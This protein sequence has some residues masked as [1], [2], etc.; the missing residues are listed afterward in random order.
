MPERS[1]LAGEAKEHLVRLLPVP[2]RRR[3][4]R[5]DEVQ[6]EV[7]WRHRGGALVGR[8]KEQVA[9]PRRPPFPPLQLMLPDLI[10]GDVGRVGALQHLPERR[11]VVAVELRVVERLGALFDQG[12]VVVGL[13][14]VQIV[15]AVVGIGRDELAAHRAPYLA[16]HGLHQREQVVGRIAAELLDLRLIQTQAVAQLRR[17]GAE[18]GVHVPVRQAVHG[19]A[20]DDAQRHRL[21]GGAG[22]R[23]A[24]ARFQHAAAIDHRL[25][26]GFGAEGRVLAQRAPE[27]VVGDQPGAV[28]R[29][30][31]VDDPLH[32]RRERL[33]H[34]PLLDH[35]DPFER[36]DKVGVDGEQAHELVQALVHGAVEPGERRQ[37]AADLRLL[38]AVLLEEAF[39]DH[40]LDVGAGDEELVE[41][42]LDAAHAAG[43]VREP[44]AV[45]DRL[46]HAGDEAEAQVLAH[47]A[48]LAQEVE[49]E[50][51][52]LVAAAP[53]VVEQLIHHQQQ[54]LVRVPLVERRHHLLERPFV[55]RDRVG[56]GEPVRHAPGVERRF[57]L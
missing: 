56:G 14:E 19:Q 49:V 37:V 5:L 15:L 32:G 12:V 44:V 33:E 6:V 35:G 38:V 2:E 45:E 16:Q 21:V 29:Q 47:L 50:H 3:F 20:V 40:E 41:A 17:G 8:P 25:D 54:P 10:A 23:L 46:L 28:L 18:R 53:Q 52:L 36:V 22:V 26:V 7:A 43:H 1:V 34:L 55:V 4:M 39:G 30:R 11:V 24:D 13:L 27:V 42:I 31:L 57:E 51:Q 9:A 48:H